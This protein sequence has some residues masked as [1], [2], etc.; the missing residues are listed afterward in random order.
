M[1]SYKK[2]PHLSAFDE[3]FKFK[4][5]VGSSSPLRELIL[6]VYHSIYSIF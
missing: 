3:S 2:F 4:Y 6:D 5:T 1:K